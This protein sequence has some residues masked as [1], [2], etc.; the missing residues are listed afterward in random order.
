MSYAPDASLL[1]NTYTIFVAIELSRRSWLVALHAPDA[2]KVGLH[3][4]PAGD[5]QA[6]L[7]LLA[8]IRARVERRTGVSPRVS[9]CYEAGRD[10]FWLHRLL[11]AHGVTSYVMDPSSLQVDRRAR[12]AKTDRLDAQALLRAL[13]AWTRGEPK[14]CSMVRPPSPDEEDARRPSRER[15]TLLQERIRLVNRIK[16]LCATQGIDAYE[17]LRPD[18]RPRLAQL[19]TGDGR[20]LPPRLAAEIAHQLDWLELVLRQLAEVETMRDAEATAAQAASSSKLGALL[21]VRSIGPEL[22]TI[23]DK[24]VFYRSF[25]SRRQVAAY[26]GLTPSPFASGRRSREQGISKAGSRRL[27]TV[28]VELAWLWQRYQPGAAQ[29][30]WFRDRVGATGRRIRKVMVVALARKLLIALWRYAVQGVVPDGSRLK[31]A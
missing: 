28:M 13:M 29:V 21:Q 5:G 22:A 19:I 1:D 31:P 16:G 7:D 17:P 20:P 11:E 27:R 14:V 23:L 10:G 26:S 2:A 6:V 15:A 9:C 3:R 12:R 8:R 18:R 30:M 4:L 25:A 24:E